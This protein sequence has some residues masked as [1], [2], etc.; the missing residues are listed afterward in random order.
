MGLHKN[1]G[2]LSHQKSDDFLVFQT[3]GKQSFP[4]RQ[5]PMI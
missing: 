4:A 2:F 5:K 3:D 1:P